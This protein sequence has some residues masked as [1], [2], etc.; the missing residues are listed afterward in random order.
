MPK[1][2]KDTTKKENYRPIHLMTIDAN[3][4]NKVLANKTQ[5]HTKKSYTMSKWVSSQDHKDGSTYANQ[6]I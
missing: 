6:S 3:I 1:P 2:E 5:E 4:A